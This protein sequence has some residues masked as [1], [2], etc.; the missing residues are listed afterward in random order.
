MLVAVRFR[1]VRG[2]ATTRCVEIAYPLCCT[3]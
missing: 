1:L 2:R 3:L